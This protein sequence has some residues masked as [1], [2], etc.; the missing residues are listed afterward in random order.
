M[1]R[2]TVNEVNNAATL[3]GG[4]TVGVDVG[5]DMCGELCTV[6]WMTDIAEGYTG[7]KDVEQI[8]NGNDI[9]H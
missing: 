7:L 6:T 8:M 4:M 2:S 5:H 3:Y 1:C 9:G